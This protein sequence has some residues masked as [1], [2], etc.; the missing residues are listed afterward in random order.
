MRTSTC[1][2]ISTIDLIVL[3]QVSEGSVRISLNNLIKLSF[4]AAQ[5]LY[6]GPRLPVCGWQHLKGGAKF[7]LTIGYS[8]HT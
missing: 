3:R 8:S 2:C 6:F 4:D 7:V 5:V 1:V